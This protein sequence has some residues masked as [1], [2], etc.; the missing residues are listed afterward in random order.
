MSG[1]RITGPPG[2]KESLQTEESAPSRVLP[3][4]TNERRRRS[5]F[6]LT[7][8]YSRCAFPDVTPVASLHR[9]SPL[10]AA[11]TAPDLADRPP[12]RSSRSIPSREPTR[13]GNYPCAV[14]AS[15]GQMSGVTMTLWASQV[16]ASGFPQNLRFISASCFSKARSLLRALRHSHHRKAT[17]G[18]ST[19]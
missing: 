16:P 13:R 6:R 10:T 17:F 9:C 5:V 11:G 3:H 2:S 4:G 1:G 15:S 8:Q 19:R 12:H 7:G 18:P 14:A